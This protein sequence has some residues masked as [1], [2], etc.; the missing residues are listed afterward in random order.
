MSDE[1]EI[2]EPPTPPIP[3]KVEAASA[4]APPRPV[5][6]ESSAAADDIEIQIAATDSS[7]KRYFALIRMYCAFAFLGT[8]IGG[9]WYVAFRDQSGRVDLWFV[10]LIGAYFAVGGFLGAIFYYMRATHEQQELAELE[11]RK[12][13]LTRLPTTV[14]EEPDAQPSYFDRLVNINVTN[15][16][17]YYYLVKAHTNNSFIVSVGAGCIGL[18]LLCAGLMLG[19]VGHSVPE[20]I[21]YITAGAGIFTEFIAGVFFY[22]YSQ[23]VRQLKDYHD[24]LLEVQNVLLS[25]KI[26]ADSTDA[27]QRKGMLE[28]IVKALIA[29][30]LTQALQ[31]PR[32]A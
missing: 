17:A 18:L 11:A 26:V 12:R 23:T 30:R 28:N 14:R 29:P 1:V 8:A 20:P 10:S 32:P 2:S 22:L 9:G 19:F 24:S 3:P 4:G 5:R 16:E 13:I 15:L 6:Y 25:F 21:A 31:T 27:E 7:R